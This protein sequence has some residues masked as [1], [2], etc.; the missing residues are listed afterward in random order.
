[1]RSN[2]L[3]RKNGFITLLSVLIIGALGTAITVSLLVFG[4]DSSK[5]SRAL[6]QSYQ[7][8]ALAYACSEEA[9][10][11][12]KDSTSF[13]GSGTLTLEQGTCTYTVT[14]QGG[15]NRTIT[16]SGTVGAVIQKTKIIIDRI[17][18]DIHIVSWQEVSDF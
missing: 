12:I 17:N 5:T 2:T 11:H 14:S 15:Q 4:I 8:K 9:L 18:P 6:E 16:A 13:T 1:M 7:S 10:Q 3:I